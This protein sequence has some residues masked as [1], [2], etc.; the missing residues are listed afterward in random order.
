MTPFVEPL[1]D[2]SRFDDTR[3]WLHL[4]YESSSMV[5][6]RSFSRKG[7]FRGLHVQLPPA[8]QTKIIRVIS[9]SILDFVSSINETNP[10][11]CY[12][13]L[14]RVNGWIII[15]S[16]LAHGFYALEDTVFEYICDGY[17][18]E[19]SEL[20]FSILDFLEKELSIV[21]PILSEKDRGAPPLQFS[22]VKNYD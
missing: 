18:S 3:G 19:D 21:D 15:N 14:N 9:G 6:K 5:V 2:G 1:S 10:P 13:K 20:S 4:I 11:L 16:G 17:Y 8:P 12:R 7:T 22:E